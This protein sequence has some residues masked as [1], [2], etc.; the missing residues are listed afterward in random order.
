MPRSLAGQDNWTKHAPSWRRPDASAVE[1][2]AE[3]DLMAI[4][5]YGTLL[6][7]WAGDFAEAALVADEA[8]ER[9]EQGGG[10]L[11][12]AF[13]MKAVAA[14]YV[15]REHDA[16]AGARA[17]LD[18]A[19]RGESP[20]LTVWPL[21]TLGFL[22][23]SL[24]KYAEALTTMQPLLSAFETTP[25]VEIMTASYIPDAV[26][27]MVALGRR[28]AAE[29]HDHRAGNPRSSVGPPVDAGHRRPLPQ[30]VAGR[31][32]RRQRRQFDGRAGHAR[33]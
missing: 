15:G 12:I 25:G 4:A 8:M 5:S 3:H 30:H 9:A 32:R 1:R 23:V 26:E 29:P 7:V 22:E 28:A 18:I 33:T 24:G 21:M 6:E 10:S 31:R 11:A 16:R 2:G 27:A 14:A 13:S 20:R 19:A 17:A